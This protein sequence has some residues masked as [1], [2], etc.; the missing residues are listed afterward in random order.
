MIQSVANTLLGRDFLQ[1][2]TANM[3][4]ATPLTQLS[5]LNDIVHVYSRQNEPSQKI[6]SKSN[7]Y[8]TKI[9]VYSKNQENIKKQTLQKNIKK[10]R[11]CKYA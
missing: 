5:I 3:T 7:F 10:P 9:K 1:R 4:C 2:T 11:F 6:Y 8:Q